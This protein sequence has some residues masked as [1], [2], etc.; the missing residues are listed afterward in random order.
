MHRT[1]ADKKFFRED[2]ESGANPLFNVLSAYAKHNDTLGYC[3]GM[4][5]LAGLILIGVQMREEVAFTILLTLMESDKYRL[6]GM[7]QH[8]LRKLFELTDQIHAW[9]MSEEPQICELLNYIPLTTIL[10]GPF[11]ALFANIT[12][13]HVSLH[14][15][16]RLVLGQIDSLVDIVKSV[17]RGQ[18]K[19]LLAV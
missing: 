14:V 19:R 18:K 7:Y 4:N 10:A 1:F 17:F 16:D 11:M 5:Y 12:D 13:L 3:Q 9:L 6:D 8:D 15:L 2:I